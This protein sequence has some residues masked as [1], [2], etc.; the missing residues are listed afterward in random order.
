MARIDCVH[1]LRGPCSTKIRTPSS[2]AFRIVRGKSI[3]CKACIVSASATESVCQIVRTAERVR[4]ETNACRLRRGPMMQPSPEGCGRPNLGTMGGKLRSKRRAAILTDPFENALACVELATNH[5]VVGGVDDRDVDRGLIPQGG[6]H[7]F[8]PR[9]NPV[10]RPKLAGDT[11]F[12]PCFVN[13]L[14]STA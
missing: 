3:V 9:R 12:L 8:Y 10:V 6:F 4:I 11:T 1:W 7:F 2:H 5:D 13:S 14:R